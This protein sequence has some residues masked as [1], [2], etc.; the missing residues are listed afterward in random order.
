V[1]LPC[2]PLVKP[3]ERGGTRKA[4]RPR[5]ARG[6]LYAFQVIALTSVQRT[7]RFGTGNL[8]LALS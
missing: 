2:N 4:C 3:H 7:D 6:T 1:V 5:S 8:P